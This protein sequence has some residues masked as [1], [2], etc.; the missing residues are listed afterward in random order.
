MLTDD[1]GFNAPGYRNDDLVT[2]TLDHLA[3][4]EGV[5]LDNFY[6][7]KYCAPTRGSLLTG[8]MPYKLASP[9][10]NFIPW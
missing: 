1:L 5:V 7:Y 8:R 6:T 4:T 3:T 2:P 9:E 10:K